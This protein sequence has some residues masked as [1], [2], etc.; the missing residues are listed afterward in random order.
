MLIDLEEHY[1]EMQQQTLLREEN[2]PCM[3]QLCHVPSPTVLHA[4]IY[5]L[6]SSSKTK[7]DQVAQVQPGLTAGVHHL[8]RKGAA[9]VPRDSA[10]VLSAAH[11]GWRRKPIVIIVPGILCLRGCHHSSAL[12][13]STAAS[14]QS[15]TELCQ[16]LS[17]YKWQTS[18]LTSGIELIHPRACGNASRS[19]LWAS[20]CC[21]DAV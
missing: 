21:S 18:S 8:V 14:Q 3:H 10:V 7:P 6:C 15:R 1:L 2:T 17:G 5:H 9:A 4:H 19:N 12:S 11:L 16:H 13:T 20:A